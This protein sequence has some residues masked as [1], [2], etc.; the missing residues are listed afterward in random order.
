MVQNLT[1]EMVINDY[2]QIMESSREQIE[3]S[4]LG[5]LP[6]LGRNRHPKK[7]KKMKKKK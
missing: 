4:C 1:K 7:K 5:R 2:H 3:L 6:I